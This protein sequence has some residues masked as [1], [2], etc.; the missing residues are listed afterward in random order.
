MRVRGGKIIKAAVLICVSVACCFPFPTLR[1]QAQNAANLVYNPSFEEHRFC[2]QRID[3]LGVMMAVDAW[4]Q[5]TR[6]SSD[7]F[8]PCGGREC[9]VPRNKMGFQEAHDGEAYCGI[10]CSQEDY[11]E[12]LQTELRMPLQAGLRYRVSFFVSLA[13]KSPNAVA[14]VGALLSVDRVVDSTMG[15]LMRKEIRDMGASELQSIATWLEPQVVNPV[16]SVLADTK[17]WVEVSGEFTAEGGERFLTIGNFADF[18][19]SSVIEIQNVGA[20]LQGAYY[21]IDDV[22]VVCLDTDRV[23]PPQ[24][25]DTLH[26]GDIVQMWEVYFD[27]DSYELLQQSYKELTMLLEKLEANPSMRIEL[28]GHTDNTGTKE[29]NRRLS[30]NRAKAVMDYLVERGISAK[31]L[32]ASGFGES[33]PIDTNNTPEGRSRNRRVEYKVLEM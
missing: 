14:T 33:I 30:E 18:N 26:V 17:A 1:L 31:R 7:Y 4:W 24:P 8:N 10:Y 20:V 23:E 16:D 19:H 25:V 28:R 12:Y 5:P 32:S 13:D 21:Y 2:P 29:G 9:L 27:I 6:G 11:R 15:I 3:A 22:S